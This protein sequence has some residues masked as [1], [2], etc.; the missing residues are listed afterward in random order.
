MAYKVLLDCV[1]VD[2]LADA[3]IWLATHPQAQND[4]YNISNGD[5]FRF[6][7]VCSDDHLAYMICITS[8]SRHVSAG[9]M[10]RARGA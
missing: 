2:L 3:Q 7:Q 1:D 6:Q 9:L 10:F 8:S 4:G 5:Q